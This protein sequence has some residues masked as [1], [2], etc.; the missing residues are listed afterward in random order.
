MRGLKGVS[1]VT[2]HETSINYK[3]RAVHPAQFS[4]EPLCLVGLFRLLCDADGVAGKRG[5]LQ[6]APQLLCRNH[7]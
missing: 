5:R 3:A 2:G 1:G 4:P 7:H 6:T